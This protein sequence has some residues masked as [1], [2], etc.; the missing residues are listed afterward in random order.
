LI[1]LKYTNDGYRVDW[2]AYARYGSD[3]WPE[4][5]SGKVASSEVRVQLERGGNNTFQYRD[6]TIWS[7]YKLL[8]FDIQKIIYGYV[9]VGSRTE[10]MIEEVLADPIQ[11]EGRVVI[12]ITSNAEGASHQQFEIKRLLA[13]GW[14][15]ESNGENLEE[16]WKPSLLK[17]VEQ[18]DPIKTDAMLRYLGK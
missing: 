1:V 2:D 16:N 13:I 5:L 18:V 3:A 12:E 9:R 10:Q 8:N 7:C 4:I 11:A 14:H 6:E 17:D 15:L